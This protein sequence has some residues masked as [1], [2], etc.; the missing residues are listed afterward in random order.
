MTKAIL[1]LIVMV[2][3]ITVFLY[4]YKKKSKG[5]AYEDEILRLLNDTNVTKEDIFNYRGTP[6]EN[7]FE[8]TFQFYK[9][10]SVWVSKYGI[11][12]AYIYFQNDFSRNARAKTYNGKGIITITSGLMIYQI[13]NFLYKPEIDESLK[14]RFQIILP[15]LDNP[16]HVLMYQQVQHSTFYHELG[17]L[18]QKS[19]SN[20]TE[21]W[22][23]ES[24][25]DV[26]FSYMRHKLEMD[27]DSSSAVALASH[28]QQYGFKIF[29]EEID[30]QKME[31]LLEIFSTT[32][33]LYFLSFTGAD[34]EIYYEKNSHPHPLIRILNVL[35]II[36]DYLRQGPKLI[37]K[38]IDIVPTKMVL[39]VIELAEKIE[40]KILKVKKPINLPAVFSTHKA[41]IVSYFS[42][43]RG[44]P[45]EGYKS[46]SDAWNA[47]I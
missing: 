17:H 33:L 8:D 6:K 19:E 7:D 30:S 13:E 27:A 9:G 3:L 18:I 40:T 15:F 24:S 42:K 44:Y 4:R 35:L 36:S 34:K 45:L 46:A 1:L 22:M 12:S 41:D 47:R 10:I 14:E 2:V 28:V 37:D 39:R 29:G 16:I 5:M 23:E 25:M 43:V 32:V 31:L 11:F 38:G 20:E 21:Q 26:N